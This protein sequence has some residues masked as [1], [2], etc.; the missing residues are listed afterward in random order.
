MNCYG[1]INMKMFSLLPEI[2]YM[3]SKDC[4]PLQKKLE[5]SLVLHIEIKQFWL[6]HKQTKKKE[7]IVKVSGC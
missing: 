7:S 1:L 5:I 6:W 2:S 4:F 3:K